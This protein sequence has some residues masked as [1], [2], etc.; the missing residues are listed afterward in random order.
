MQQYKRFSFIM[1]SDPQ[2]LWR[3]ENDTSMIEPENYTKR[4]HYKAAGTY[5]KAHRDS[6][7]T[8]VIS[9]HELGSVPMGVMYNGDL[10]SNPSDD[11]DD[12]NLDIYIKH[13]H[14]EVNNNVNKLAK[15][16]KLNIPL[17]F[18]IWPGLGNHDITAR[19]E[20]IKKNNRGAGAVLRHFL[21]TLVGNVYNNDMSRIFSCASI[22]FIEEGAA[23]S[24]SAGYSFTINGIHIV[25]INYHPFY[26]TQFSQKYKMGKTV[27]YSTYNICSTLS[28]LQNDLEQAR[29]RG[30]SIIIGTHLPWL[31]IPSANNKKQLSEILIGRQ[32]DGSQYPVSA[33]FV[34]HQ[35]K[36]IGWY[37]E[38]CKR[39]QG[40]SYY[41]YDETPQSYKIPQF[42]CGSA[43]QASYLYLDV[44]ADSHIC[45]FKMDSSNGNSYSFGNVTRVPLIKKYTSDTDLDCFN[46]LL[47]M[48]ENAERLCWDADSQ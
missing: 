15:K 23:Y 8:S 25:Q 2:C 20:E 45:V 1:A 17:Q 40:Y 6:I 44:H 11:A 4:A 39:P 27:Y 33:V 26:E 12:G 16:R 24:G 42:F 47:Q 28:W 34:G 7:V 32:S 43:S 18:K 10:V 29:S 5:A 22:D 41:G 14:A 13:F 30:E 31:E 35:H 37:N 21:H 36:L 46:Q 9:T 48:N 3:P 19:A 38:V